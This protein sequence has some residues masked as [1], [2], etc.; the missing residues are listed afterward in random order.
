MALSAVGEGH[1]PITITKQTSIFSGLELSLTYM[2]ESHIAEEGARYPVGRY[3]PQTQVTAQ[4]RERWLDEL[5]ELPQ[6]TKDAVAGLSD[7][8]LDT[9]Y[10]TGGWTSR[11]VVHHL[12][13]SHM[14]SYMRFRHAVTE[15]APVIKVYDEARWAEL[16]DAKTAPPALSVGLLEQLHARW[17]LFLRGL[18]DAEFARVYRHPEKGDLRLD[19]A[20]GLYA[21]HGRHHVAQ[22]TGLRTR[23]GW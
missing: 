10:R 8:Q 6:K 12:A 17:I 21:W 23:N 18:G 1:E 19:T 11:Q 20:L 15:D 22:I 3:R 5:A 4:D 9:P 14:N 16:S 7:T 13:D 2:S